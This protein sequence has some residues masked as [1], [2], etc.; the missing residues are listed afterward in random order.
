MPRP[1]R[2]DGRSPGYLRAACDD[3]HLNPVRAG[4]VAALRRGWRLGAA[5]FVAR[6]A[7][8]LGRRGKAH[9]LASPRGETDRERAERIVGEGLE[10]PGWS[11]AELRRPPKAHP[12]QVKLARALRQQTPVTRQWIASRMV[13]ITVGSCVVGAFAMHLGLGSQSAIAPDRKRS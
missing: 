4:L 8:K 6:L 2:I 11:E 7:E 5:D 3:V 13:A 1:L 10:A 12:Q 9:E